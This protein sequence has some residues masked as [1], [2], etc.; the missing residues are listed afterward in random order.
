MLWLWACVCCCF[1][2]VCECTRVKSVINKP[3]PHVAHVTGERSPTHKTQCAFWATLQNNWLKLKVRAD[4]EKRKRNSREK[5]TKPAKFWCERICFF[6]GGGFQKQ[7]A[8]AESQQRRHRG[9]KIQRQPSVIAVRTR[10]GVCVGVWQLCCVQQIQTLLMVL[11]HLRLLQT[12]QYVIM[13][14]LWVI[15]C[16]FRYRNFRYCSPVRISVGRYHCPITDLAISG[17]IE[18]IMAK[19]KKNL[20]VKDAMKKKKTLRNIIKFPQEVT[21]RVHNYYLRL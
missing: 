1:E 2:N 18:S 10:R 12:I 21:V 6:W 15:Y 9:R 19:M 11:Y 5:E 14:V 8:D 4:A 7:A 13:R 3:P 17:C 20:V 16:P